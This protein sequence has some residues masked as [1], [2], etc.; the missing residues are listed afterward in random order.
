MAARVVWLDQAVDELGAILTYIA[1]DDKTAARAYVTELEAVCGK[2][3]DFPMLGAP[4]NDTYYALVSGR[5]RVFY[6]YEESRKT[7]VIA[8]IVHSSRRTPHLPD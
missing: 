7:V 2:L 3:A 6:R 4:L 8:K 5:H 1:R